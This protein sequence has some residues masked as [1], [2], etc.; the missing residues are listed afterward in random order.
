MVIH[1]VS[2]LNWILIILQHYYSYTTYYQNG[3]M[4][5]Q[6]K[7]VILITIGLWSICSFWLI[8]FVLT[9]SWLLTFATLFHLQVNTGLRSLSISWNGLGYEGSVAISKSLKDNKT[10]TELDISNNRINWDG[11]INIARGLKKNDTLHV[12][13]V[14]K[15]LEKCQVSVTKWDF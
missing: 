1:L 9:F 7:S 14:N 8:L 6:N 4:S 3:K 13:K 11:A 15:V 5:Q 2:K 12:M 10:L